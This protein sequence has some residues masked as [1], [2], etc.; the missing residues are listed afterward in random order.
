MAAAQALIFQ[1][2]SPAGAHI[3][4]AAKTTSG[5]VS[6]IDLYAIVTK[7]D[8]S[9]GPPWCDDDQPRLYTSRSA[10]VH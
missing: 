5:A 6:F 7:T 4:N 10:G 2:L 3:R 9:K 8:W 1:G